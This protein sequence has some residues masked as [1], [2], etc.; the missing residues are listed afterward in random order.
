MIFKHKLEKEGNFFFRNRGRIPVI[1]FTVVIPFIFTSGYPPGDAAIKYIEWTS[2]FLAASGFLIR[3]VAVGASHPSSSGRN[4]DKQVAGSLNTTGIYSLI[5][6]PLY[7]GNFLMWTGVAVYS[8]SVLFIVFIIIFFIFIYERIIYAEECFLEKKFGV[9]FL[10]WG[11]ITPAF[12]PSFG[13]YRKPEVNF[14]F[15]K[16]LANEY[17][18]LLALAFSFVYVDVLRLWKSVGEFSLPLPDLVL[19]AGAL[20]IALTLRTLKHHTQLL[21]DSPQ[22]KGK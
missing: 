17:S 14:S 20:F 16:V 21:N 6:H 8:T 1:L 7:A 10:Y 3:C 12:F 18:G 11:A 9:D 19:L 13:H 5:R 15:R 22:Q 4:R 2:Y